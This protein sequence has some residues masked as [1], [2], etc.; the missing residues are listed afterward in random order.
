[1]KKIL[2]VEDEKIMLKALADKFITEGFEVI[3]AEDGKKGLK[4]ALL[5]KPD[6][7]LLDILLP[8]MDGMEVLKKLRA[9]KW[10]AQAKV[11]L[12]TNVNDAEIVA[13][14]AQY[15]AGNGEVYEYLIKTDWTLDEVVGKVKNR[16]GIK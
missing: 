8:E 2:I 7:I 12:L 9:D 14:G 5:E 1:M 4:A 3:K 13:S 11:I 15:G 16:L 10:G 6:M